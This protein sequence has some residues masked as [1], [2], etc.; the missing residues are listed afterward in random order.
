[1]RTISMKDIATYLAIPDFGRNKIFRLLRSAKILDSR[2]IPYKE[3]VDKGLFVVIKQDY[4]IISSQGPI[5][6]VYFK[7]TVTPEGIEV[8]RELVDKNMGMGN[9][10]QQAGGQKG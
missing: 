7:T 4:E 9:E 5:K 2:N 3:Y 10:K 1:M 8:I 6:N